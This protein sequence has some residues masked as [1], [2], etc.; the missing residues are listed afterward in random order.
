MNDESKQPE[1]RRINNI[2]SSNFI[3]VYSNNVALQS[4]FFD[5]SLT[6]GEMLSMDQGTVTVEQRARVTMTIAH[7]KLFLAILVDQIDKY[8]AQFGA[9]DLPAQVFPPEILKKV[10]E[11]AGKQE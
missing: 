11:H 4:N 5:M 3:S 1:D 10:M 6:F 7:A 2:Q 9:V 8:E